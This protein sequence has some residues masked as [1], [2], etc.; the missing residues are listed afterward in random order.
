MFIV[1]FLPPTMHYVI[2]SQDR[3]IVLAGMFNERHYGFR[4]DFLQI[5]GLLPQK[6]KGRQR[7][8]VAGQ[9]NEK[10]IKGQRKHT[11]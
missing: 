8:N 7:K 4:L 2:F 1:S 3:T 11:F 5:Y 6:I 9:G 10:G